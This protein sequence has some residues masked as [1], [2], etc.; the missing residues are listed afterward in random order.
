VTPAD[1]PFADRLAYYDE[2]DSI[3]VTLLR[4]S[5]ANHRRRARA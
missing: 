4:A 3:V 1:F 5:R 2:T